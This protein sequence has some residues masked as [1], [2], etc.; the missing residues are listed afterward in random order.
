MTEKKI[1]LLIVIPS[2]GIG[3]QEKIAVDTA[4]RLKDKLDVRM[5]TFNAL[6]GKKAYEPPCQV[7]CLNIPASSNKFSKLLSQ[8]YRAS[9]LRRI[10]KEFKPDY[11]YSFGS[12]ANLTNVLSKSYGKTIVA[13]HHGLGDSK[14]NKLDRFVY[15]RA[16]AVIAIS[17]AMK[18]GLER[19]YPDV[20]NITTVENGYDINRI[21]ELSNEPVEALSGNPRFIAVGRHEKVK[22]YGRLITAFSKVISELPDAELYMV[23]QGSMTPEL[24]QQAVKLGIENRAHFLGYQTNPFKYMRASDVAILSSYSEGLPNAVIESL[25]CGLCVIATDCGAAEILSDE[26]CVVQGVK[27]DDYGVLVE[28]TNDSAVVKG[29]A[30][31]MI[32][33]CRDKELMRKYRSSSLMRAKVYSVD[34]YT[35]KLTSL[36]SSLEK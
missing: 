23:G 7:E 3:G 27:Y 4:L 12:T 11:V 10:G 9:G 15:K 16:D 35:D 14:A 21:T 36:F 6:D 5:V 31:A 26:P 8:I 19:L 29:M 28:N 34:A 30:E 22:G 18:A 33:L 17:K 2:L 25:A 1:K 24:K 20:K 13:V 32:E